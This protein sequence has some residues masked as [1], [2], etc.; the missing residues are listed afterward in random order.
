M[1]VALAGTSWIGL[2]GGPLVPQAQA[3]RS[4]EKDQDDQGRQRDQRQ[5]QERP[6][7]RPGDRGGQGRGE[8]RGDPGRQG[9]RAAPQ[10]QEQPRGPGREER[11]ERAA[12]QPQQMPPQQQ[13]PPQ[14]VAPQQP[15]APQQVAPQPQPQQ[16]RA[17]QQVAPQPQ[18]QQP[19]R[20]DFGRAP[21]SGAP[22]GDPQQRQVMPPRGPQPG[23]DDGR[24]GRGPEQARPTQP[25]GDGDRGRPGQPPQ[26][27]GRPD[28]RPDGGR[29]DGAR[30]AEG[31]RGPGAPDG[32]AAERFQ[33][34]PMRLDEV[35]RGRVERNEGGRRVIEE[36]GN[37]VIIREKDRMVI[38]R[39]EGRAFERFSPN[40]RS[41]DLGEG[42][43]ETWFERPDGTRVYS[44]V[45]RNGRILRR[46]RRDRGGREVI[47][48]DNRRFYRNVAIGIGVG[49]LGIGV[50]LALAPPAIGIPRDRYIVDYEQAS[51]DDLYEALSAPPVGRLE[52][53]YSLDEIRY[54]ASLRDYMRRIDLDTINFEFGSFEVARDQ[55]PKLA[56]LARIIQRM[57]ERNEA[58][59]F[60]IEG[61]T[62][63][64]GSDEDNLTLSDRRAESVAD[65]LVNEF[66]VP[67][68]NLVTQGYGEQYLKINTQAPE[69]QNRRVALRRITPLLGE[70]HDR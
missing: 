21:P 15:R 38:R 54:S 59:M 29:P 8:G 39:D 26:R 19:Q 10:R 48:I 63:A 68:E 66:G 17:P 13:R 20:P 18:P 69:R 23:G 45:D 40:A 9:D 6:Q 31:P 70:L 5:R 61:H 16:P 12:P 32:R 51:D 46:W 30:P 44:E 42:R 60:L 65:I 4:Q 41:R 62:D 28:G 56:R 64:V 52:R 7:E 24:R 37:R 22:T 36:P 43:R 1:T 33:R 53:G 49:A 50:G 11:R 55:Y 57:L 47:L 14:Q 2:A 35:K 27:E 34:G 67:V 58:E 25:G 3:Q